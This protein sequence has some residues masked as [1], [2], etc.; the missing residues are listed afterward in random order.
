MEK[1]RFSPEDEGDEIKEFFVL[2][3]T[4]VEGVKYI[5]VTEEEEGD[6]DAFILKEITS[7]PDSSEAEYESVDNDSELEKAAAALEE[8]L[9]D[10][11][12][13]Q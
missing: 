3:Q 4:E 10:V 13:V 7:D 2:A 12:L 5:L 9:T 6:A 11:E 8:E 1:I